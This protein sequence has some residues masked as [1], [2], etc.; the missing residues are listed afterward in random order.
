MDACSFLILSLFP[1]FAASQITT[2][3]TILVAM[4]AR[5]AE[6]TL[7]YALGGLEKQNYPPKH[8][9]IRIRTDCNMDKTADVA[10]KWTAAVKDKYGSV[11]VMD[12]E[13]RQEV[14][15]KYPFTKDPER[16]HHVNA[17][18]DQALVA[19]RNEGVYDYVLF[20]D[21]D[22]F[23]VDPST[24]S[25]LVATQTLIV[26]PFLPSLNKYGNFW[27]NS[28]E[29][30][31]YYP[32]LD[33]S[34]IFEFESTGIFE[35]ALVHTVVLVDVKAVE[36]QKLS[37]R[38]SNELD[39][40]ARPYQ[41]FV[42]EAHKAGVSM[43]VINS[44]Q[45][46]YCLPPLTNGST[47]ENQSDLL[48]NLLMEVLVSREEIPRSIH[49]PLNH[50][51]LDTLGFDHMY[52]INLDR[53]TERRERM[54]KTFDILNLE[55]ERITAVDG[56]KL[57]LTDLDDMGVKMLE[58]YLD[59]YKKR[60]MTMGE[61][62]CYLSHYAIWRDVIDKGYQK[63]LVFEDDIRFENYFRQRL[64]DIWKDVDRLKLDWDLIYLGRK[65]L[66]DEYEPFVKGSRQ[67]VHVG[68]S[69]WTLCYMLSASGAAKLLKGE[70]LGKV[71][72]VDEYLPIMFDRHPNSEWKES[73]PERDLLAFSAY[74]L[75]VYPTHYTK[76]EGYIS[77]T[78]NSVVFSEVAK[79]VPE[80]SRGDERI[81]KKK[82][83]EMGD[84]VAHDEL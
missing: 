57:T 21:S 28:T 3:P 79:E 6:N 73:F 32:T 65:R 83:K 33:C 54:E 1:V 71:L 30:F 35:V 38:S 31:R 10:K 63:V 13:C 41:N 49:L 51:D 12:S 74:P 17:M 72:P 43:H 62:G 23:L 66:A 22:A 40:S 68:Y 55:V 36:T 69:Y 14:N 67:I 64:L 42:R 76:E 44:K 53:R 16:R 9:H 15:P 56:T 82:D 52:L 45:Y 24:I 26:S 27:C 84:I 37:F 34:A 80:G 50:E 25:D 5:N 2:V 70:P 75:L 77:D 59:P 11:A 20:L 78:E 39:E 46:G 29:E 58:G 61:F 60:P 81:K 7:P 18:R 47:L 19:A 8:L 48:K 4:I